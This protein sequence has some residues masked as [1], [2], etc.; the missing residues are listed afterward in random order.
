MEEK[1][2]WF[3]MRDLH[4]G[5]AKQYIYEKLSS[6]GFETYSPLVKS[7]K[8]VHGKAVIVER[9][10]IRDLFFIHAFHSQIVSY[11]TPTCRFQFRYRLGVSPAAPL[12]VPDNAMQDFI[13]VN[14]ES[15]APEFIS[16]ESIPSDARH[17]L[18]RVVGGPLDGV[19]G[20]LKKVRGS[21]YKTL[22]VELPGIMA[23]STV[24]QFDYIQI[25]KEE[26]LKD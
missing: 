1:Q 26:K 25:L 16:S 2:Q 17:H 5:P 9:P 10:F 13:R 6:E 19:E 11:M 20:M 7:R 12:V 3:V 23:I 24:S 8:L 15:T 14:K 4:R 21:K 18:I 22:Y